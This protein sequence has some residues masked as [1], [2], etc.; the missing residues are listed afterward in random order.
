MGQVGI[1]VD[2][3]FVLSTGDHR[4]RAICLSDTVTGEFIQAFDDAGG[5]TSVEGSE[6]RSGEALVARLSP[7]GRFAISGE[8]DG[9]VRIRETGTGRRVRALEGHAEDVYGITLT[10]DDRFL[11]SCG[12]D[13]T[14]RLWE[15]D[16][17]PAAEDREASR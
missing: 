1:S 10:P 15:F 5:E 14:L 7:D 17:E 8:D 11:L 16:Q 6:D 9:Y 13:G 2:G 3:R 12:S 4:D